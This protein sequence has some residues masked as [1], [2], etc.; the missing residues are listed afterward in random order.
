MDK[1]E[2]L[3]ILREHLIGEIPDYEI[4]SNIRYYNDYISA[5][6][7]KKEEDKLEELG[8]PRLIARTIIDAYIASKENFGYGGYNP[9]HVY[10]EEL[11]EKGD[12]TRETNQP[13]YDDLGRHIK[14]Y[15][16]DT[17]KWYQKFMAILVGVGIIAIIAFSIKLF[18]TVVLPVLV[19][20]FVIRL[21]FGIFRK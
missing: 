16:W 18:F 1:Q 14:F 11:Y 8:D 2:F 20:I 4:E 7:G 13:N 3:T 6:D 10:D 17:L 12:N 9:S 21:I 5:S 15:T 19:V